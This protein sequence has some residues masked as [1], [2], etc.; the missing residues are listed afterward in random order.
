MRLARDLGH[1]EVYPV[2]F[3]MRMWNDSVEALW[4]RNPELQRNADSVTARAQRLADEE[5]PLVRQR[6]VTENLRRA[7]APPALGR[8]EGW[9][10]EIYLPAVEGN[11]Y[12]GAQAI[13]RWYERNLRTVQNLYRATRPETR[14]VLLVI[15]S[16]HLVPLRDLLN[17]SPHFCPVSPL[18]YLQ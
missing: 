12:G 5:A 18:P 8:S 6:T 1:A 15:G 13:A 11:N 7:N 10:W 9:Q 16:G 14:R 2:D 17:S 3:Q 4:N